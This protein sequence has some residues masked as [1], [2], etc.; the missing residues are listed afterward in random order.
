[1]FKKLSIK[2]NLNGSENNVQIVVKVE[3]KLMLK[4]IGLES[5]FL[6]I[7]HFECHLLF[8]YNK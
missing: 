1:M 5:Y 2:L 4:K 8:Y 6:E 7:R 3:K